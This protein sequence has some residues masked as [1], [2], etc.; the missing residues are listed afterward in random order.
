MR[1]GLNVIWG[2]IL[3][4]LASCAGDPQVKQYDAESNV[5][6]VEEKMQ[7]IPIDSVF[8]TNHGKLYFLD[9][10]LLI[11]DG[12]SYDYL[13]HILDKKTFQ[14]LASTGIKG[15]GPGEIANIGE[16]IPNEAKREFYVFDHGKQAVFCF[17]IDS[18]LENPDYL[19]TK[20][21]D[22]DPGEFPI[23]IAYVNDT[24]SYA[25]I[26]HV[27]N[28]NDYKPIVAKWNMTTNERK[29]FPYEGHPEI[30]RKRTNFAA[31]TENNRYVEGYW[32]HDLLTVCTL[33]GELVCNAYG[34]KWDLS[35][36]GNKGYFEGKVLFAKDKIISQYLADIR[37][38]MDKGNIIYTPETKL[39]VFDLDGNYIKTLETHFDINDFCYDEENNR[40]IFL[41]NDEMQ[42]AYLDLDGIL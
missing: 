25:Q 39:I 18:V 16:L 22:N 27:L 17:S 23:E 34:K 31:S 20:K 21:A 19:P 41:L 36:K 9:N 38:R 33:E 4:G 15:Q 6:E 40:L 7:A 42:F 28:Y 14:H 8:V 29:F 30:S 2:V 35:E 10:Y 37:Y 32:Y 11:K 3:W 13:I 1:K 26:L 24:L 5:V 12:E